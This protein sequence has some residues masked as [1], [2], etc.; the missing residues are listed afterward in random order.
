MSSNNVLDAINGNKTGNGGAGETANNG[1]V[2]T[3]TPDKRKHATT[4][5]AVATPKAN[6]TTPCLD[7]VK[8]PLFPSLETL[9]NVRNETD[10]D[11]SIISKESIK[12]CTPYATCITELSQE[13]KIAL[14]LMKFKR[15]QYNQFRKSNRQANAL[16]PSAGVL[17][18]LLGKF[19]E[20]QERYDKLKREDTNRSI[21]K[22][23]LKRSNQSELLDSARKRSNELL[24][25]KT[26]TEVSISL[27]PSA[28]DDSN[29]SP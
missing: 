1:I 6:N 22:E 26:S 12:S 27:G 23:N 15:N 7:S 18:K 28:I 21:R 2:I 10:D 11:G 9:I 17:V 16:D 13:K 25:D 3:D 4:A 8:G 24:K 19:K 14:E 29:N 20:S 5:V